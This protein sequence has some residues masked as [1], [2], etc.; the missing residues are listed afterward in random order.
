MIRWPGAPR[1]CVE[2][3]TNINTELQ[4]RR[5][6]NHGTTG[7]FGDPLSRK[8]ADVLRILLWNTN[9][10]GFTT[11]DRSMESLKMEKLK[12]LLHDHAIDYAALTELNKNWSK[13]DTPNTI[14]SATAGWRQHRRLQVSYNKHFPTDTERLIGGTASMAMDD[15]VFRCGEQGNDSRGLGRWS[16]ITLQGKNNLKTTII[17]CYCPVRSTRVS[18]FTTAS[19]HV[20]KLG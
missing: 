4:S 8:G 13:V 14:W 16:Y 6:R 17:T 12:R 1:P 19:L 10:I 18:I 11:S 9:G 7:I 15:M 3:Q 20:K 5:A 2:S